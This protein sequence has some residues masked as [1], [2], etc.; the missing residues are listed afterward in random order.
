MGQ[1]A[2]RLFK[3]TNHFVSSCSAELLI[4]EPQGSPIATFA[5]EKLHVMLV[6][7]TNPGSTGMTHFQP[8]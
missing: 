5:S 2:H 1:F 7:A 3:L 8:T 6:H 4:H